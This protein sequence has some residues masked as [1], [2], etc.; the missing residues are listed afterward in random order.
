MS[1]RFTKDNH[2]ASNAADCHREAHGRMRRMPVTRRE[3]LIRA[4]NGFGGLALSTLLMSCQKNDHAAFDGNKSLAISRSRPRSNAG[5]ATSVIYLFMEGGPS[6]VDTFDPKPRL[7]TDNGKPLPLDLP[8]RVSRERILQSPFK[9]SRYGDCGADVSELFPRTAAHVDKLAIIR[10]MVAEFS[11]HPTANYFLHTGSGLRGRPSMGAWVNYGLG[12]ESNDLPSYVV[13]GSNLAP[14]GGMDCLGS[15]FLPARYQSMLIRPGEHPV[16]DLLPRD[17]LASASHAKLA[18]LQSLDRAAAAEFGANDEIEAAIESFE[19]AYR[20]QDSLPALLDVAHESKAVQSLYGLDDPV[21]AQ[22]GAQCL[23]A[24]RLVENGVRFVL[25]IPAPPA[26]QERWDQ[27]YGLVDGHRQNALQVD[28]PIAGLIHDLEQS[29]LLSQTVVIWGGEFG[30]TPTGETSS[31]AKGV[32]RD[33]N[34][35]GFTMWLCGGGVRGGTIYGSTDEFGYFAQEH[36]TTVHDLH[37][38]VLHLLGI[39][40]TELTYRYGGRDFRLT[41]VAGDVITAIVA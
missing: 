23:R 12:S 28:K 7:A 5:K 16:A 8:L 2:L 41:D 38:T 29:G 1:I 9:F 24:R 14:S 4:A 19:K 35:H 26:G 13:L 27:H 6:Q 17:R 34:P 30:R 10:S 15:G 11:D 18:A 31:P 21:A 22:F 32:G 39:D 25:L 36:P 3:M 40:H 37:A 33:H 20:M